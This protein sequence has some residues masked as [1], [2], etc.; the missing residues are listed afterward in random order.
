MSEEFN[1][2]PTFAQRLKKLKENRP[3]LI[4]TILLLVAVIIVTTVAIATNR[5]KQNEPQIP[6]PTPN[7]T[8]K[9]NN[10]VETPPTTNNDTEKP[11]QNPTETPSTS[12]DD[13]LPSFVLP[14]SGVLAKKHDPTM[15]VFSNTMNDYRVHIGLDITTEA[16]APVYAAADGK[17]DKIWD[18]TLMGYCMAIKHSGNC[19]TIY[20]NLSETLPEGILEGVSVRSGQLIASVGESAMVEVA[21][22]PHLHFEM[23]VSDLGVDPLEYFDEKALTSLGIDAS[24]G[25]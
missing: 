14:V 13:K 10:N 21:E 8:E 15:Q 12:V 22:E 2:K 7:I 20:K 23:T 1:N 16:S 11:T 19:Y 9:P 4:S 17:I 24:H 5:S 18:D 3:A 25:E 6:T